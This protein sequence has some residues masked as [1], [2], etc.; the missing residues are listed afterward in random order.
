MMTSPAGS[1]I[2]G[3]FEIMR[4][5][6]S[7]P[8]TLARLQRIMAREGFAGDEA[9]FEPSVKTPEMKHHERVFLAPVTGT[10]QVSFPGYGVIALH[11]GD[12][13][14]IEPDTTHDITAEGREA[15][16]VLKGLK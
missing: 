2:Q 11:P 12:I 14:A 15:A 5:D 1:K 9:R 13:L 10:V 7:D 8:P 4:W 6:H 16:L 3:P